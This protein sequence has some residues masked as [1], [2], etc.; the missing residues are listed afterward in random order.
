MEPCSSKWAGYRSRSY[1]R[2]VSASHADRAASDHVIQ[3]KSLATSPHLSAAILH[4]VAQGWS[5]RDLLY[6]TILEPDLPEAVLGV[7]LLPSQSLGAGQ[8]EGPAA[9]SSPRRQL[10]SPPR[11]KREAAIDE[12]NS[13]AAPG[14]SLPA[15]HRSFTA[16]HSAERTIQRLH[17]PA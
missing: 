16:V 11:E 2:V 6:V 9:G 12:L 1:S 7:C 4:V 14:P 8:W 3:G 17:C 15:I 13:R 10:L 5:W